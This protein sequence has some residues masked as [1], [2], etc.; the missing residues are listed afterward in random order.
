[1][2][3][4]TF[5]LFF[6][7]I[8]MGLADLIPGISGG[9]IALILGIYKEFISSLKSINFQS[10]KFLFTLNFEELNQQINLKFLIPIFFG[11]VCAIF[12][13]SSLISFLLSDFRVL[14][15]SFFFSLI[16]FSSIKL[17]IN[18]K[19]Y[20]LYKFIIV[21]IGISFGYSISLINPLSIPN[22]YISIYLSGCI[23]ILAMLIPGISGSYIL[24]LLGKY[25]YILES[26]KIL[27]FDI[28]S[29]FFLGT[30]TGIFLFSKIIDWLLS[31]YY[32]LSILFLSGLMLGALN[33]VWPWRFKEFS[34]L[35][36]HYT[37][38]SGDEN[39]FIISI[40]MFLIIGILSYNLK[41]KK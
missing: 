30:V 17:I 10:L 35:P 36:K 13:F 40:L 15:F 41:L 2:Y 31:K 23:A 21:I 37:N 25:E 6:N 38:V 7:G 11:I 22:N 32:S 18:Q 33:K 39:Y 24:L 4:K 26:I 8:F 27:K 14:V 9:T 20:E 28:I 1:M 3:L 16:L 29:T 34:Y 12:T 19:P 5:K